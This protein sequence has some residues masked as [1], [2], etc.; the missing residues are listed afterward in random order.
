MPTA[1][2]LTPTATKLTPKTGSLSAEA[3]SLI[4]NPN[5]LTYLRTIVTTSIRQLTRFQLMIFSLPDGQD[6]GVLT[7]YACRAE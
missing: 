1:T 2:G 3:T 4:Q 7:P 6:G 5:T